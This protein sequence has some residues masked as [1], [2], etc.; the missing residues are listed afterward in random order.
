MKRILIIEDERLS[1]DRLKRLLSDVDDTLEVDGPLTS[2]EE[3][4]DWL[5]RQD[6]PTYDLIFSDIRLKGHLVFEAFHEVMPQCQVVFTTA[7]DEYAL[8]AF[9]HN[10]IDYLLKPV[11]FGEL[12]NA[13]EKA[14][15]FTP[16]DAQPSSSVQGDDTSSLQ[17]TSSINRMAREMKCFRERILV[18][19]GD[20]LI[21]L[22]IADISFIRKEDNGVVAYDREGESFRLP[23]TM[24]DLE[25]QLNP[26][27]FFRL[28]RQYIAHVDCIRKISFFF[29]SKLIVRLVGCDDEHIVVSKEK[30][31]QFKQWLDR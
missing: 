30:S 31:A 2:V 25:E 6:V 3:V 9:R 17:A 20:E 21:P 24:N 12:G 1:A 5:Q 19:K 22:R 8:T 27:I 13:I 18:S 28:N 10:A 7:Y 23:L 14:R 15:L 11:D 4:I 16:H 29:S 26:E